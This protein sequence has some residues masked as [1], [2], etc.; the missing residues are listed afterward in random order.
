MHQVAENPAML[1]DIERAYREAA[2]GHTLE[3][4][5]EEADISRA[6][7]EQSLRVQRHL[8]GIGRLR[9]VGS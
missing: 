9:E 3:L 1:T 8:A 2:G 5:L 4:H 6:V 7:R